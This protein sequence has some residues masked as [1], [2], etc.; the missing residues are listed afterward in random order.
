VHLFDPLWPVLLN[1]AQIMVLILGIVFFAAQLIVA[2]AEA[3]KVVG[4]V[5][6]RLF[7]PRERPLLERGLQALPQSQPSLMQMEG[8]R[9][10]AGVDDQYL[11]GCELGAQKDEEQL[12]QQKQQGG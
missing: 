7:S 2:V 8:L 10:V 4:G 3:V 9:P 1:L 5:L 12:M 11:A 6:R